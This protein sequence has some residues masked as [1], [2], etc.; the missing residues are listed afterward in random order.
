[1]HMPT[2]FLP[3]SVADVLRQLRVDGWALAIVTN[4]MPSVQFRKVAAL[5]LSS[6]VDEVVYAEEHAPGGKPSAAPFLAALQGLELA[7]SECV[8][9]GDDPVRDIQGAR[10]LGLGT[11]R[12]RRPG[13][14]VAPGD[15]AD[16]LIESIADL[17]EALALL[18]VKADVA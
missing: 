18:T 5:G 1:M 14:E 3:P 15:E 4:G 17:P 6:M 8:C 12:L 7:P 9:V 13:I 2:L 11:I 16:A 10:A